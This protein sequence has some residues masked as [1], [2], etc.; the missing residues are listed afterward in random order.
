MG[1]GWSPLNALHDRI[2]LSDGTWARSPPKHSRLPFSS[3]L[4]A[5]V[6]SLLNSPDPAVRA[7]VVQ[8][9]LGNVLH[10]TV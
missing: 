10:P 2:A 1:C 8:Q 6:M 9:D 4:S 5:A 3:T 7:A